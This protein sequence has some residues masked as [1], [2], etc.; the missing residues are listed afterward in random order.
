[1]KLG[2]WVESTRPPHPCEECG[3]VSWQRVRHS[4][5]WQCSG[6]GGWT[7]FD[8]PV[9]YDGTISVRE[10]IRLQAAA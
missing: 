4:T 2:A 6:C 1:M 9:T 7:C 8:Y 5:E 10:Y 3:E